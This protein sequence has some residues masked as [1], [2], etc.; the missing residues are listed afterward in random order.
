MD[1]EALPSD[2]RFVLFECVEPEEN[3][4]R[5]Y[6]VAW[7]PT[8]F[9]EGAIV[10]VYGCKGGAQRTLTTPF[11]SLTEAWPFIRSLI[12]ARLRHG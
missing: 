11:P 12:K 1:W 6:L 2:F 8:L 7:L 5:F 10:G 4:H 9:E 3:V